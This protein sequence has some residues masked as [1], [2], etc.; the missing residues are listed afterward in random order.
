MA[1]V[2]EIGGLLRVKTGAILIDEHLDLN[3]SDSLD[4]YFTWTPRVGLTD[5]YRNC[6]FNVR[7]K[8]L[9]CGIAAHHLLYLVRG[10]CQRQLSGVSLKNEAEVQ[11]LEGGAPRTGNPLLARD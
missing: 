10:A 9:N 2:D 8:G 3:P 11:T 6:I 1:V 4:L 5:A 7:L